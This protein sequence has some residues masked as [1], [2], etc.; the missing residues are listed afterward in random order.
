MPKERYV[1]D[2][3]FKD[4]GRIVLTVSNVLKERN[5]N[6]Y[7][8]SKLTGIKWNI[9]KKYVE[10]RLYRVDLDLLSRMCYALDCS[11]DE[12]VHYENSKKENIN[13]VKRRSKKENYIMSKQ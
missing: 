7:R 4:Y 12:L 8:L 5:I 9:I 6:M 13:I 1:Y 11:L 10:G 2:R 3:V